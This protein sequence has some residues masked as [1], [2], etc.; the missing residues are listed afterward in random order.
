MID[1][2]IEIGKDIH[3]FPEKSQ[4]SALAERQSGIKQSSDPQQPTEGATR[5]W[6]GYRSAT[7]AAL[8]ELAN[9][10]SSRAAQKIKAALPDNHIAG[11]PPRPASVHATQRIGGR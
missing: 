4:F 7:S 11:R 5:L 2:D 6:S 10:L 1:K 8:D 3:Q 9:R